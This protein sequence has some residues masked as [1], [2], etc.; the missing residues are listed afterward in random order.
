MTQSS[1]LV[2]TVRGLLL[3]YH[4][5]LP[6]DLRE[7]VCQLC[8]AL[9]DSE[10]E[11]ARILGKINLDVTVAA[12]ANGARWARVTA[13]SSSVICSSTVS[14]WLVMGEPP[15]PIP[16]MWRANRS[17]GHVKLDTTLN[18]AAIDDQPPTAG[19]LW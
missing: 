8:T 10:Q 13:W 1:K 12:L 14:K 7:A 2:A 3:R 6:L 19:T 18:A 15:F 4:S 9:E 11:T 5:T 17:E 16:C